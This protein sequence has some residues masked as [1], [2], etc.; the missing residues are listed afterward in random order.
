MSRQIIMHLRSSEQCYILR[1]SKFALI[2]F[3][4]KRILTSKFQPVESS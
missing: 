2:I 1:L 4:S 3:H